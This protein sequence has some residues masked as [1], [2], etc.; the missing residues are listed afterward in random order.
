[1]QGNG[2]QILKGIERS[3]KKFVPQGW[4]KHFRASK[5]E[6]LMERRAPIDLVVHVGA[7]WGE[8]AA[9]YERCGAKTILWVEADPTTY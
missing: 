8:D 5:Y 6:L 2:M 3:V 7:H 4:K 1:M 9:F